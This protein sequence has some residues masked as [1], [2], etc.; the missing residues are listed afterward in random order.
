MGRY[1]RLREI[2]GL[3]PD[4]DHL[5]IYRL[6]TTLE[7]PWD[8]ARALELALYRTYAVPSIGRLLDETG[9]F[10]GRTQKR[11][12]DTVLLLD[13]VVEHGFDSETGRAALRRVNLMHGAYEISDE[14]MRYVL[15]TFVVIP[16]RWLDAYGWRPLTHHEQRATANYYRELGRHL[17]IKE[18][19]ADFAGFEALLN[20][21]E[22]AHFG[23]D[24]GGRRVADATLE[25]MASWYP[26]P[27]APAV[28]AASLALLDGP[29]LAAFRRP[30]P[31]PAVRALVRGA[32]RLRGRAVRLLPPRRTPHHARQNPEVK[33]YRDGYTPAE[34]GTFPTRRPRPGAGGCPVPHGRTGAADRSDPVG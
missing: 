18:I 25:L 2:L 19:P 15:A 20:A 22:D 33:G 16:K 23:W 24:A 9:E 12:D 30:E 13:A 4:R 1:D 21:Y 7:F 34:L 28:R 26:A 6:I 11:Y 8:H 29:L 10:T 5:E 32:V 17:G 31:N 27:L 14:D 3:D